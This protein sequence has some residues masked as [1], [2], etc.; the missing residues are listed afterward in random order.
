MP[1]L[2]FT[3]LQRR[4]LDNL[5]ALR[6]LCR[7]SPGE[8]V[9]TYAVDADDVSFYAKLSD[10]DV[11]ILAIE[12]DVALFVPRHN[13]KHLAAILAQPPQWHGIYA[14]VSE[15]RLPRGSTEDES[16]EARNMIERGGALW[17]WVI[18]MIRSACLPKGSSHA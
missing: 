14:A 12:L 1:L 6:D 16:P 15:P 13:V 4:N 17:A 8:A 9:W 3:P 10:E 18:G 7:T 5:L 11:P 2:M